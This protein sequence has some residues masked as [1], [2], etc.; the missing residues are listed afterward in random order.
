MIA[1]EMVLIGRGR[2]VA[3]GTKAE[4]LQTTGTFV[5]RRGHPQ[6]LAAALAEA[7]I[8]PSPSGDGG[9]RVEAEPVEVGRAAAAAGVVLTE[10]RPAEG[11]GLEELFLAAHRRR[12]PRAVLTTEGARHEH[13]APA[14]TYA[15]LD[16]T[17]DH[18]VAV[19]R[20]VTRRAA[21]DGRHPRRHVA[22]DRD[23][24]DHR[25]WSVVIFCLRRRRRGPHL[26]QLHR[27]SRPRRRASCSR[28]RH[29]AGHQRVEPA[30]G[31][32]D[33]H[34]RAA[35]RP[36][37]RREGRAPRCSS[38]SAPIVLAFAM[39]ALATLVFGGDRPWRDFGCDR[40]RRS[41]ACSR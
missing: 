7:G 14:T 32:G 40:L 2:I 37:H 12:R 24:G 31:D 29:P 13:D 9:L 5:Q 16:L 1:D 3:Q 39:A 20:L 34:P 10:L 38:A 41:S 17:G 23:R 26:H 30:H 25:C 35:P 33:V 18:P 22:A 4:L 27:R 11:A 15:G 36:D 19:A 28:A 21:Q 6:K 8:T